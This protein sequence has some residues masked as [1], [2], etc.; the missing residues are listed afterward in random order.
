MQPFLCVATPTA[1]Y[2][3]KVFKAYFQFKIPKL[4][5]AQAETSIWQQFEKFDNSNIAKFVEQMNQLKSTG[6]DLSWKSL[7]V[8]PIN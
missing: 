2:I 5:M 3:Y 8:R 7:E 4:P 1:V 6:V